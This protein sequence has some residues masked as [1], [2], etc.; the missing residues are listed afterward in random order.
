[1]TKAMKN[2]IVK[3]SNSLIA[4]LNQ[5]EALRTAAPD[6]GDAAVDGIVRERGH[7]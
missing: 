3:I 5:R 7:I 1:M 6:P 4:K 2:I